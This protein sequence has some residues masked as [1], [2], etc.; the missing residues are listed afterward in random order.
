MSLSSFGFDGEDSIYH[1][2]YNDGSNKE[3]TSNDVEDVQDNNSC[4]SFGFGGEDFDAFLQDLVNVDIVDGGVA[5]ASSFTEV[6]H[7]ND[8]SA[9]IATQAITKGSIVENWFGHVILATDVKKLQNPKYINLDS[10]FVVECTNGGTKAVHVTHS[11][12]PNCEVV[13]EYELN[14]NKEGDGKHERIIK[15]K[16]IKNIAEGVQITRD[17]AMNSDPKQLKVKGTDVG[18][19]QPCHC[20]SHNCRK[21]VDSIAKYDVGT[22]YGRDL[23]NRLDTIRFAKL[24]VEHDSTFCPERMDDEPHATMCRPYGY[25]K[26]KLCYFKDNNNTNSTNVFRCLD[27]NAH[28]CTSCFFEWH[29]QL[30]K[31]RIT[32]T[33]IWGTK[34][35]MKDDKSREKFLKAES[36][37]MHEILK[38]TNNKMDDDG[39]CTHCPNYDDIWNKECP[40]RL[41][42][43]NHVKLPCNNDN[44]CIV[45]ETKDEVSRCVECFVDICEDCWYKWHKNQNSIISFKAM[46]GGVD[47]TYKAKANNNNKTPKRRRKIRKHKNKRVKNKK[48]K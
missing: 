4:A 34:Y 36:K 10:S 48:M 37:E 26:C 23:T 19:L 9:L 21:F 24:R 29:S 15:L 42:S 2:Y 31:E 43:R 22:Q 16:A 46:L 13:V 32:A 44:V 5:D 28:F 25:Q 7:A 30:K 1:E 6:V 40:Q 47:K 3:G 33:D 17:F 12:D 45:C 14:E 20:N 39:N 38:K 11:C 27:C 35:C 41:H 8:S 18:K